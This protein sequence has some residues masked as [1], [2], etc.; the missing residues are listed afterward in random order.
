M[1][2]KTVSCAENLGLKP[3]QKHFSQKLGGPL[4]EPSAIIGKGNRL[5]F[6]CV[7]PITTL[8]RAGRKPIQL[9]AKNDKNLER[10]GSTGAEGRKS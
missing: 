10:G 3:T 4:V 7:Y 9:E 2:K 6:F 5:R 1:E 8:R